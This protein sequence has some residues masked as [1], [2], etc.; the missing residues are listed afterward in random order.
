MND[1]IKYNLYT[2][3]TCYPQVVQSTRFND[4]L[5]VIFYYQTEPQMVPKLL[6]HV[7]FRKLHN[8]LVSDQNDCGLQEARD[9]ENNIIISDSILR[10]LFPPQ[11]KKSARYKVI[12][13]CECFISDKSIHSSLLS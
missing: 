7:S 4:C 13:G 2:W 1:Q 11:L 6:L 5:K 9:E 3:I 10:M 12:C 8:S